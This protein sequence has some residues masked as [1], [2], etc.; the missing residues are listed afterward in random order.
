[1]GISV[2]GYALIA[3]LIAAVGVGPAFASCPPDCAPKVNY[4]P[5]ANGTFAVNNYT[6]G[7]MTRN[8]TS[9]T[10]PVVITTDKSSYNDG[11][12]IMVSGSVRDYLAG[13]PV[14][15]II[16]NSI[17]N[18]VY[19]SQLSLGN[20]TTYS[21][22]ISAGG[23]LWQLAGNYTITAQYGSSDR[24]AT[25]SFNFSGSKAGM[26]PTT[27]PVDGTNFTLPYTITNGKV[28]DIKPDL[29][30]K[31]LIVSVQTTGD[32]TLT[33]TMPRALIDATK[34][35]SSDDKYFVLNDDQE[36]SGFTETSTTSTDRTL[37]IPFT[38]GTEKIEI[39]GTMVVPEFG[40]IAALILA[41]AIISIIVLSAKT[42]F[43]IMPRY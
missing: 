15:L 43:R 7:G 16:R 1:L 3:I 34:K 14:S 13:T 23:A 22:T 6:G 38:V 4:Q 26:N 5:G 2:R 35:D 42:G 17:G 31:S 32:G 25:T 8:M 37:S 28:L 41:I 19:I 24:T 18:V 39:I 40:P 11:E 27:F 10:S 29:Q 30:A 21:A 33:I 9:T 36:N 20:A 12:K